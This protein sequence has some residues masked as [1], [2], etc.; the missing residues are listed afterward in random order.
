MNG[1]SSSN[2][3]DNAEKSL[4]GGLADFGNLVIN[5]IM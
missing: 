4:L 1:G 3:D 2:S 5:N